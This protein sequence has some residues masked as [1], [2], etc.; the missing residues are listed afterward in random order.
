LNTSSNSQLKPRVFWRDFAFYAALIA[1]P[2]CWLLL[3]LADVPLNGPPAW[4]LLLK[5]VLLVPILE[6]IVFR[7][8]LQVF[9]I[10]KRAFNKS[11]FGISVANI[12][13]S[14]IF[15]L[16]H[17]ISQPPLWAALVFIPSLVFGWA[18]DRYGSVIP[19]IILHAVY[20]AGFLWLFVAG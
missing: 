18:R 6:E 15:A 19:S 2:V 13:T 11:W 7:G 17:L 14:I 8:G 4:L 1:G 10:S 5:L 16:M 20:N 9:L 12:V 3:V